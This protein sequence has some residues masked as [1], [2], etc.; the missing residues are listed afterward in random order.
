MAPRVEKLVMAPEAEE[1]EQEAA[2]KPVISRAERLC[3][4]R[5]ARFWQQVAAARQAA[6]DLSTDSEAFDDCYDKENQPLES[7]PNA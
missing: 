5:A 7:E 2:E 4:R 3:R 1:M 6:D